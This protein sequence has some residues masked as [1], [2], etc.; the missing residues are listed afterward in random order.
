MDL[1]TTRTALHTA[2]A[3][4]TLPDTGTPLTLLDH[5]WRPGNEVA[6]PVGVCVVFAG[7]T[8]NEQL[9][10]IQ[11]Y[12][13]ASHLPVAD[14]QYVIDEL[15]EELDDAVGAAGYGPSVWE[16]NYLS[17]DDVWVAVNDLEVPRVDR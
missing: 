6:T 8:S 10:Q 15:V 7:A 17:S 4:V 14:V 9:W 13:A 11:G 5:A 1:A 3:A 12:V 16:I 2:I